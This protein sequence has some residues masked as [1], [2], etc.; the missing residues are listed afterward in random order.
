M[1][2]LSIIVLAAPR[3]PFA[4]AEL[5][6]LPPSF[7]AVHP[8]YKTPYVSIL[9][10]GAIMLV[11]SLT[12]SFLEA[13]TISTLAR[14]FSYLATCAALPVLRR[15]AG[16]PAALFKA[17]AGVALSV[18]AVILSIWLLSIVSWEEG[19]NTIVAALLGLISYI[20]LRYWDSRRFS[21][22]P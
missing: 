2:N 4:M 19:R 3:I 20:G 17:P 9:L 21:N 14:L 18:L 16:V 8:R 22:S 7:S 12:G 5:G 1:G 15:R 11:L 6:Q 10:S 13:L